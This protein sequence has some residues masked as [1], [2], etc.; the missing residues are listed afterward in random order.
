MGKPVEAGFVLRE[1]VPQ[2]KKPDRHRYAI[3]IWGEEALHGMLTNVAPALLARDR[4]LY[5]R[6]ACFALLSSEE[7][8]A[9]LEMRKHA[10]RQRKERVASWSAKGWVAKTA[11]LRDRLFSV[12]LEAI[13]E[14]ITEEA[15]NL[16]GETNEKHD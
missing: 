4:E 3:T 9:I 14:W 11:Q 2:E 7:R 8:I 5:V 16:K 13:E 6:T 10:L 1:V 15:S 12:E